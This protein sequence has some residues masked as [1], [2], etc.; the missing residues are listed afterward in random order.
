M[1][2]G[3]KYLALTARTL[4]DAFP[5]HRVEIMAPV[6][7]DRDRYQAMLDVS[8]D[9]IDTLATNA[10]VTRAH[11][12]LNRLGLLRPLRNRVLGRQA[13]RR[14]AGYDLFLAMIYA[15]PVRSSARAGVALCQ[16]PYPNPDT[17]LEGYELIVCYSDYVRGWVGEYWRRDATIVNPPIDVPDQEVDWPGKRAA[18]VSVGRF[19]GGGHGK[20]QDVLVDVFRDICDRGLSGWELHLAGALHT[21]GRHEGVY[22]EV[23]AAAAGYPIHLHPNA[24]YAEI[25]SLYR[26]ASIYWHAAGY[27]LGDDPATAEHFG[28]TTLEAMA[29]GAVPV[30]FDRGGQREVVQEDVTGY[31]WRDTPELCSRTDGLIRDPALRR[32]LGDAARRASRRYDRHHF[33]EHML[34]VLG[35][36]VRRLEAA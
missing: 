1:G 28:M 7:V 14:T 18:I 29:H 31:L 24:G 25:Q 4:R 30:V 33:A 11:R 16:F 34:E 23:V 9:G 10:R 20:R 21:G 35:P 13:S 27:G 6:P 36:I 17:E 2:G 12:R 19:F 3:E 22:E 32:R 26:Q 15:I 5:D 8:L